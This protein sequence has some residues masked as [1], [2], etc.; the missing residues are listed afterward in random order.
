MKLK[1][2]RLQTTTHIKD[3]VV[4]QLNSASDKFASSTDAIT[5]A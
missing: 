4:T 3:N 1:L 5:K 2:K